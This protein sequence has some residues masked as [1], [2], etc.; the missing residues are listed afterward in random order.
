[1]RNEEHGTRP[2]PRVPARTAEDGPAGGGRAAGHLDQAIV[3][4]SG[5]VFAGRRRIG[6][7]VS[8]RAISRRP[9][10]TASVTPLERFPLNSYLV[11]DPEVDLDAWRLEVS[12][13]VGRDAGH[14]LDAIAQL[15]K[16]VQNTR[17][18]CVEGWSVIG[19][20]GGV[21]VADFLDRVGA[22]PRARFL[23]VDCADDYYESI[24]MASAR[25]PQSL[26]C[27]EIY[28]QPLARARR[29]APPGDA[30]EARIQAGE[31][32][33]RPARDQ[34]PVRP[35]RLLG[36]SVDTAGTQ[37]CDGWRSIEHPATVR[38]CHW[39]GAIA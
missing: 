18:V 15:P 26:L 38:L 29:T 11:D 13:L 9:S 8:N 24:D 39:F 30:H 25:H 20:F 23:E 2:E 16:V 31:I 5:A 19:N 32:H 7:A 14:T 4:S 6:R 28:G 17:H 33:R 35:A 1:M 10:P 12:G 36:G 21:R 37:G 22:D 34:R 27:Y 3:G